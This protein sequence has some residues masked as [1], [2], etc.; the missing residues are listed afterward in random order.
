VSL[1]NVVV[2]GL[3]IV[4]WNYDDLFLKQYLKKVQLNSKKPKFYK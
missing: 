2:I 1:K 3:I 4:L